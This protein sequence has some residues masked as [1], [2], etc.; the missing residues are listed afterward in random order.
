M[1]K[2]GT[3]PMCRMCNRYKEMIDYIVSGCP[4]LAKTE[5]IQTQQGSCIYTVENM[6]AL[7]NPSVEKSG[8][9]MNQ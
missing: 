9:N 2:D 1:I 8:M 6:S 7:Q 3:D 4:E 5:K